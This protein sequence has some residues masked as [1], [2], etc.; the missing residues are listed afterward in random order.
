M[1]ITFN[2]KP[3]NVC[4]LLSCVLLQSIGATLNKNDCFCNCSVEMRCLYFFSSTPLTSQRGLQEPGGQQHG[5]QISDTLA[6]AAP[7][8][9]C[10]PSPLLWK[11]QPSAPSSS[12]SS[13]LFH[14]HVSV[15]HAAAEASP[16][17]WGPRV[18]A[19]AQLLGG[20]PCFSVAEA[21]IYSAG[22]CSGRRVYS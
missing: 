19:A 3:E 1:F 11:R 8:L 20:S 18:P 6:E 22:E 14:L 15:A 2:V 10:Y 13:P 17:L 4:H 16:G 9:P 5:G 12:H 21:Q 7:S